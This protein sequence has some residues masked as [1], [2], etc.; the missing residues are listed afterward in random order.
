MEL[1]SNNGIRCMLDRR[2]NVPS[3][4][5]SSSDTMRSQDDG[6]LRLTTTTIPDGSGDLYATAVIDGELVEIRL[7]RQS[8]LSSI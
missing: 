6:L 7:K 5:P 4:E 2:G 3:A 8:T 1:Q